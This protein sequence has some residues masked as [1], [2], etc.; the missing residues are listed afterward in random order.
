MHSNNVYAYSARNTILKH[1]TCYHVREGGNLIKY[2]RRKIRGLGT[3]IVD[4]GSQ[5]CF[6]LAKF[7]LMDYPIHID[8]I[9]MELCILYFTVLP[10]K[11]PIK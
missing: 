11:N 6:S 10:V 7:I 9:S 2:L 4:E 8:T 1:A 5:Y 3:L